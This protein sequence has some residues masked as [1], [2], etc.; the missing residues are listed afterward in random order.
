MEEE[1]QLGGAAEALVYS[2][3]FLFR[4][5]SGYEPDGVGEAVA[6]GGFVGVVDEAGA[7]VALVGGVEEG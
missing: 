5:E 2:S 7:E 1:S 4:N 3:S 6:S